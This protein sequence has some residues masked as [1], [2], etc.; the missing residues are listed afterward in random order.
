MDGSADILT[1]SVGPAELPEDT[2]PFLSVCDV[3]MLF[4]RGAGVFVAQAGGNHMGQPFQLL[5]IAAR[6]TD[7]SY[8]GSLLG[9]GQKVGGAGLPG[10]SS[11]WSMVG[12]HQYTFHALMYHIAQ[13]PRIIK[14]IVRA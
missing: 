10:M 1:L 11:W 5:C 3:F 14:H 12:I 13:K 8:P 9:N 4:A 2:I 6:S 7:R